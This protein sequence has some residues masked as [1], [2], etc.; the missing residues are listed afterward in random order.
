MDNRIHPI[1]L[2][3]GLIEVKGRWCLE[4]C[5]KH[6]KCSVMAAVITEFGNGTWRPNATILAMIL[7]KMSLS[8]HLCFTT[9][10]LPVS[11][12]SHTEA[13]IAHSCWFYLSVKSSIVLKLM[14]VLGKSFLYGGQQHWTPVQTREHPR[15]FAK[16]SSFCQTC[17]PLILNSLCFLSEM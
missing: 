3:G 11:F 16:Y 6:R 1:W 9:S 12:P 15:C 2:L 10:W 7:P 8:C 4:K 14:R 17:F 13:N 5:L